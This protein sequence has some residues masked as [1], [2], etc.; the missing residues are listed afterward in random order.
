[1]IAAEL[2]NASINSCCCDCCCCCCC[3]GKRSPSSR[4]SCSCSWK[5]S[6]R[7]C[8]SSAA[9]CCLPNDSGSITA[10]PIT[11][12]ACD[13]TTAGVDDGGRQ[14]VCADSTPTDCGGGKH[15]VP[16]L[17]M[18]SP[19]LVAADSSSSAA[20]CGALPTTANVSSRNSVVL[21]HQVSGREQH[22]P[23]KHMNLLDSSRARD[24]SRR[25]T[26]PPTSTS[27]SHTACWSAKP[28]SVSSSSS[29]PFR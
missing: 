14:M 5:A 3:W 2:D 21:Q 25:V 9:R 4:S 16:A 7:S 20:G 28:R 12:L 29:C 22:Q 10:S 8:S 1:V 6:L 27:T 13:T 15:T 19:G 17:L 26:H 24:S 11:S 23:R 18:T